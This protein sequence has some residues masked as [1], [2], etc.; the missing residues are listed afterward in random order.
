MAYTYGQLKAAIQDYTENNEP[1]FV[2]N[3]PLFI[4]TAEE[5]ILKSVQLNLFRQN[6]SAKMAAFNK[7]LEVPVDFIAPFALSYT[8]VDFPQTVDVTWNP[9]GQYN[10]V[11][12]ILKASVGSNT[13][14]PFTTLFQ[15]AEAIPGRA[16]ADISGNGGPFPISGGDALD[17]LDYIQGTLSS[18]SSEYQYIVNYMLPYMQER[19]TEYALYYDVLE[20]TE[21]FL[22]FKDVSFLQEFQTDENTSG[23]PK[24]Y[25]QFNNENF[26]LSPTPDLSYN[27]QLSYFY[28]P[29]SLTAGSDSGTT[30]LSTN[31]EMAM[32]YGALVEAGIYMK[33]EPDV[34][35]LY[36]QRFQESLVGIKLLG[37]AKQ[38]TDEYRTGE[39]IRQKQ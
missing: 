16:L 2:T 18:S 22:S 1:S 20:K 11:T 8:P 14:Y 37:E 13:P 7:Y 19:Q 25:A 32:F 12:A 28:R 36:N 21:N 39:L 15:D 31:A 30:W 27:V 26:L 29:A 23:A 33:E 4:R 35:Q 38:T 9:D 10:V 24:Y 5:R 17:M 6:A 3:I 34:M